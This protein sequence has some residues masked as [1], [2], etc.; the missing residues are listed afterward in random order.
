MRS[1][2]SK[3]GK[4]LKRLEKA[5]M[6]SLENLILF[7]G[8]LI[9]CLGFVLVLIENKKIA[10]KLIA[11]GL[12]LIVL[13][14]GLSYWNSQIQEKEKSA[15]SNTGIIS[16]N[17]KNITYPCC[18]VGTVCSASGPGGIARTLRLGDDQI[19]VWIENGQLKVT[20]KVRDESGKI[21]GEIIN[22][23][24]ESFP[25]YSLKSNH[26]DNGW[27]VIDPYGRVALQVNLLGPCAQIAGIFYLASGNSV[28]IAQ[29]NG[30]LSGIPLPND[31]IKKEI[32]Q[33]LTA[34]PNLIPPIFVY[35][36]NEHPGERVKK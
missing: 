9:S 3:G 24:F 34:N 32:S 2:S 4:Y 14:F 17:L 10:K 25:P 19:Y 1:I 23:S 6:I 29:S 27:E 36:S 7:I 28:V 20:A 26:D 16:S 13:S 30:T 21:M 5:T 8:S 18:C 11:F 33:E 15:R 22:G 12:V 31:Q 35:P